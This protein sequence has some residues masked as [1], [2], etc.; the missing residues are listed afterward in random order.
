MTRPI[1]GCIADDYTGASDLASNLVES[2]LEV[3]QC[4]GVPRSFEVIAG[5]DAVVI[6]LKTRSCHRNEAVRQSLAALESLQ[7]M[8][9]QRFYFKYSS[10]FDS[11]DDG[12]IGPVAEALLK[13]LQAEQTLFCPAFPEY[14]RT[15]YQGHLFV[16]GK[17]LGE[18]GMENHPLTPMNDANLVRIL[19]KQTRLHV[20]SVPY[21]QIQEGD[22]S[23]Q[24]Y[25]QVLQVAD[26]R[27][28]IVDALSKEHLRIIAKACAYMPLVT[29]S[30]GLAVELPDVYRAIGLL[31]NER[32]IPRMTKVLGRTAILSGSCS[33]A[34]QE[35]VVFMRSRCPSLSL[36]GRKCV[37]SRDNV[38]NEAIDWSGKQNLDMPILIYSTAVA[39]EVA[40]LQSEFGRDIAA[41]AIESTFAAIASRLVKECGVRR[42]IV[43]GG[44][45]SGAVVSDLGV[46][47]LRIGP[48][49]ATGV[50]WTESIGERP[51]AFALKAGNFG[52][53][54]FF[55][56]AMEMLSAPINPL[57]KSLR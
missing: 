57:L 45:T 33:K 46:R 16:G 31:S 19:S 17:L 32:L 12:N 47:A 8:G 36:D 7:A 38:V 50:P 48:R 44:E 9:A 30:S 53:P 37:A 34:T 54:D 40:S 41:T 55:Q 5:A 26:K 15:V 2:G 20:G 22:K 56:K 51:L 39:S 49:I 14:S 21:G 35:Q 29:G 23:L 10:T 28:I 6:A 13:A 25:L 3:V 18:S 11:T 42:M 24:E 4:L 27:F 43:A 52:A 1:I